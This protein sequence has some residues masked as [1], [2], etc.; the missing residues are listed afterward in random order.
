MRSV[1]CF[2]SGPES[3]VPSPYNSLLLTRDSS[4]QAVKL[5]GRRTVIETMAL[6]R[7]K[8]GILAFSAL[9]LIGFSLSFAWRARTWSRTGRSTDAGLT[10]L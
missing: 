7:R 1:L 2:S 4:I 10:G 3:R 5:P 6:D 8:T 9:L